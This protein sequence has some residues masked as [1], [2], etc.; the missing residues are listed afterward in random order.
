LNFSKNSII[1]TDIN[2]NLNNLVISLQPYT[3]PPLNQAAGKDEILAERTQLC[4]LQCVFDLSTL[5]SMYL[6]HGQYP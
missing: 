4:R 1:D 2:K 6:M 3:K 5:L